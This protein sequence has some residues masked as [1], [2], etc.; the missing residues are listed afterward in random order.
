MN[1]PSRGLKTVVIYT[2]S[3]PT[4]PAHLNSC[5]CVSEYIFKKIFFKKLVIV[6]LFEEFQIQMSK[7]RYKLWH[8]HMMENCISVK[9]SELKI[10]LLYTTT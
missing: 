7:N 6:A 9:I 5:I 10:I 2:F 4:V 1:S 3:D 8:T